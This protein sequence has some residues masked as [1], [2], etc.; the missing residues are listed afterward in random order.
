MRKVFRTIDTINERMGSAARWLCP[1]LVLLITLEVFRR[2]AFNSP[3]MWAFETSMM[4]GATIYVFG[5]AYV[6]RYRAHIRVDVFYNRLP[7][8]MRAL[9]DV[10]GNLFLFFPYIIV[11]T[12]QAGKW[13][14]YAFEVNEKMQETGWY[15]PFAPL[16]TVLTIGMVLLL[17]QGIV[18]FIRDFYLL[19][20]NKSYE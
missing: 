16:R 12:Y 7:R 9:V 15:P 3:S 8:R 19:I 11:F 4:I 6:H 10:L 1:A 17:V 20:R 14:K 13:T 5:W 18:N 2:F